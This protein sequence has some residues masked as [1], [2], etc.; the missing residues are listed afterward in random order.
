MLP[1]TKRSVLR[2]LSA[3]LDATKQ[4]TRLPSRDARKV[5]LTDKGYEAHLHAILA[6][7]FTGMA[8]VL[9]G[10]DRDA[11]RALLRSLLPEQQ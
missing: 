7:V 3:V 8:Q 2:T 10:G 5:L 4:Q 9:A 6:T 11:T 1:S